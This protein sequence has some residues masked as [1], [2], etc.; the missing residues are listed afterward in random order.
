[1][2]N[3]GVGTLRRFLLE[4]DDASRRSEVNVVELQRSRDNV[5]ADGVER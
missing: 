3:D 4:F 5:N 2:L 1:M